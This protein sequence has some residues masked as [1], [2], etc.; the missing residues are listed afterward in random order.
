MH[1]LNL[2]PPGEEYSLA[3]GSILLEPNILH[4]NGMPS[5]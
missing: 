5:K 4:G 2:A 3:G 1:E